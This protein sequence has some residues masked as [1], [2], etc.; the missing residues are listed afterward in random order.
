[1]RHRLMLTATCLVLVAFAASACGYQRSASVVTSTVLHNAVDGE[2]PEAAAH[3]LYA[4]KFDYRRADLTSPE[5]FAGATAGVPRAVVAG[6]HPGLVPAPW[7]LSNDRNSVRTGMFKAMY[8]GKMSDVLFVVPIM[9]QGSCVG[10][11]DMGLDDTGHW[12]EG[13]ILWEPGFISW[14]DQ[15]DETLRGVLGSGTTVRIAVFL[16]SGL[17]FAVG[18]N[19][20]REAAVYLTLFDYGPG[21]KGFHE[22]LPETGRLYTPAELASLLTP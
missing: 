13:G 1:V 2:T 3:R 15:A 7:V 9:K 10:Q 12:S 16:P 19:R 20:D 22:R 11:F 17:V 4:E 21:L 14:A 8:A 6:Y 18:N 5:T